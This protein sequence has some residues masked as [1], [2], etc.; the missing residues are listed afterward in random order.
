MKRRQQYKVTY[1]T[2]FVVLFYKPNFNKTKRFA[3]G[4]KIDSNLLF[5]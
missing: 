1:F 3:D 4:M 2:N 5:N